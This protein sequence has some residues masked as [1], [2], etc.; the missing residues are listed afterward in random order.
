MKV[1]DSTMSHGIILWYGYGLGLVNADSVN[2]LLTLC[3]ACKSFNSSTVIKRSSL[4]S[5]LQ[6][7]R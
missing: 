3:Y 7:T 5:L 6:S 2:G 4:H 1:Q